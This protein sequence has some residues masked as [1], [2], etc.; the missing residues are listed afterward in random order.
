MACRK[1]LHDMEPVGD[2]F[3]LRRAL[4]GSL[5]VE[6]A[7]ISADHF[8]LGMSFQPVGAGDHITILEN[9]DDRAT[10]Q[11]DNDRAVGLRLPPA[12]VIDPDDRRRLGS[13]LSTVLQLPKHRVIAYPKDQAVQEPLGRPPA[14]RVPKMA[15]N[16]PDTRGALYKR[17]RNRAD[18]VRESPARASGRQ[19]PPAANLERHRDPV[20]TGGIIQ[21][22][23]TPPAVTTSRLQSTVWADAVWCQTAGYS[24]PAGITPLNA[25]NGNIAPGRPVLP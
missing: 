20:S 8:H 16:F 25:L 11:I 17:T 2:L 24:P 9:I 3:R 21:Q 22:P 4:P 6:T 15:D 14:G 1:I 18:L 10:L 5:G 19:T 12:P 23:A 7:A 13:V